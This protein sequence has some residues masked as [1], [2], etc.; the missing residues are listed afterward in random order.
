M[1]N[2]LAA[3]VRNIKIAAERRKRENGIYK[4]YSV[5]LVY[6]IVYWK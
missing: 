6:L 1:N 4:Y 5:I 3:A 2:V